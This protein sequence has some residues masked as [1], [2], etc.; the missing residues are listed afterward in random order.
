MKYM[1]K[2]INFP[3][4]IDLHLQQGKTRNLTKRCVYS[5][6]KKENTPRVESHL[7]TFLI[8][9]YGDITIVCSIMLK[10]NCF[11]NS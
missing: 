5:R 7:D 10:L 3:E 8:K 11:F 4:K 6:N 9:M 2:K 1:R